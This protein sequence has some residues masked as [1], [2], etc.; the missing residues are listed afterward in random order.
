MSRFDQ[1][2]SAADVTEVK[3]GRIGRVDHSRD[4]QNRVSSRDEG[5]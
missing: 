4:V 2:L 3:A 1:R 5:V